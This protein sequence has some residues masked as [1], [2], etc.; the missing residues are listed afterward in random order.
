MT[1]TRVAGSA[2]R[3]T[4]TVVVALAAIIALA[5][6]GSLLPVQTAAYRSSPPPIVGRT[7]VI[8]TPAVDRDARADL[9]VAAVRQAPGREGSVTA[10]QVGGGD[11]TLRLTEQGTAALLPG[12][13]RPLI[14]TGEGVMATA[15]GAMMFSRATEGSLTGLMAAPCTAPNTEH[16]FV[17]VGARGDHRTDLVLTNPD[18]GAAEVDLRFYGRAGLVVVPGSPGLVIAGRSSRTVSLQSLVQVQGPLTVAVRAGEGR[19]SAIALDRRSDGSDPRG[20]DWQPGSVAPTGN[21]VI[22]GVPE[23]AGRRELVVV[24]PG[25]ERAEVSVELLGVEGAFAP[26]G[27]EELVV[28][29]ESTATVDLGPGLAQ[30]AGSVRLTSAM[31]VTAAVEA[32][33]SVPNEVSDLAIQPAVASINRTGVVPLATAQDVDSEFTLSNGGTEPAQI[34]FEVFSYSGVSLRTDDIVLVP[35]GSVSRRL[36]SP[37]PAFLVVRVP[38]G[39][40]VYGGLTYANSARRVAGLA[41]IP[42][43]SPDLAGSAPQASFDPALGQ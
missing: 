35:G 24:N 38:S 22:P 13:A 6:A 8:C 14:M 36:T 25:T 40:A 29:P 31:P 42:I 9:A 39:S 41:T 32:L 18:E 23:G 1:S 2:R 3:R 12:P 27:A 19:V 34:G 5:F 10:R 37:A 30:Q 16:W 33:S 28:P 11:F 7:S 21:L 43:I 15:A 26:V 20:A 4:L 17:A